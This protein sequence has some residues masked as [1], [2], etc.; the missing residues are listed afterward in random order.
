MLRRVGAVVNE[1]WVVGGDFNAMLNK[2]EKEGGRR[3][4]QALLKDFRDIIDDLAL[5]DIKPDKGWFT[6][7]NNREGNRLIKERLD[8]F[9]TSVSTVE[10]FPFIASSVIRQAQSDHD[11]ILLDLHGRK[12]M[13][14]P[15]DSRLR[16]RYEECWASEKDVKKIINEGWG[17]E[18]SNYENKLDTIRGYLGSWQKQKYWR[19]NEE[20]STLENKI[21]KIID[22]T[23]R[24]DSVR[25]LKEYRRRLNFLY[26]K[27]ERYW[28]Q[29]SRVQWLNK[30]ICEAARNYF[31]NLF[32]SNGNDITQWDLSFLGKCVT[33]ENND[34][35]LREYNEEDIKNA[36]KQMDPRKG[37]GIDGFSGNF[38]K[39]HWDIVGADTIR[40]Y[41]NILNGQ[42]DIASLN[43]TIIILIPK[44]RYPSD[45]TNFRPISLCS[46]FVS[47]RM[48]HDNI[49]IAH[50]LLHYHQNTRYNSNKGCVIKLDMSKGYDRVEWN[51]LEEVM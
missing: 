18:E 38:F 9:L 49:L 48:I 46:A 37:P 15:W 40:F 31:S 35:L 14:Y 28:A 30:D 51:F 42:G 21:N 20:I 12:L 4:T 44:N 8:R 17:Q 41:L 50:E 23:S 2:A 29:R 7:V 1:D 39:H 25:L 24:D 34:W 19:T 3:I 16:F 33:K 27:V 22:S 10:K 32:R 5:V 26:E 43:E 13:D 36:I 47:G 45:F 11:A 6:W